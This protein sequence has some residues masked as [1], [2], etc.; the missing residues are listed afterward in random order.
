MV[1]I[2]LGS[3]Q[4]SQEKICPCKTTNSKQRDEIKNDRTLAK[5][6]S[7][8]PPRISPETI[9]QEIVCTR[10]MR[11]GAFNISLENIDGQTRVHCYGHG[12][13]GWTTLFGSI[14]KALKLFLNSNPK[15]DE[16]V[17]V[18]GSG[19]MGLNMAIEL[20]TLGYDVRI[21]TKEQTDI[22]SWKAAGY[23]A[24]V[25][26]QTSVEEQEN[27][28]EIG[29]QTFL[30]YQ[31]IARG[32]HPYISKEAVKLMPVYC[33]E[34]TESGL[35]HLEK[36][37]FIPKHNKVTLD[38]RNG[39]RH[40]N[41]KEY[42]TYF[43]N[44]SV[45]MKQLQQRVAELEI[46]ITISEVTSFSDIKESNIINCAGLG[47]CSLNNDSEMIPVTGHLVTLNSLA[48]SEHMN[49]MIY[50]KVKQKGK[51]QYIYLFPKNIS[52]TKEFSDG[53]NCF[54]VLGGT[55]RQDAIEREAKKPGFHERQFK[56]IIQRNQE[57]FWGRPE[58]RSY[59]ANL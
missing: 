28:N 53:K 14:F 52:V 7:L 15:K 49:Y 51:D 36:R 33:S 4:Y 58:I 22:A 29:L 54:G 24:L 45:I 37:G 20:K 27:L 18:I 17:C 41:F 5:I 30:A 47:N 8:V 1:G 25:S 34:D 11:N 59:R 19:C 23:F 35:E 40:E 39:V 38:F 6:V 43:L 55:F 13:S 32:K 42:Y 9:S 10:P 57:F 3:Y 44:T 21:V 50:S 31:A 46:P 48:G 12:G 26:L 2:Q 56:K 16:P